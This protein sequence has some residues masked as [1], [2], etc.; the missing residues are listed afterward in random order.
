MR[1]DGRA[2]TCSYVP[3]IIHWEVL[4]VLI[5]SLFSAHGNK[6][7]HLKKL[8][9]SLPSGHFQTKVALRLYKNN[10]M[11]E[12]NDAAHA[13]KRKYLRKYSLETRE[14]VQASRLSK[15]NTKKKTPVTAATKRDRDRN[16]HAVSIVL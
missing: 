6:M 15:S 8:P 2:N 1:D 11:G 16:I 13:I 14:M 4:A 5:A 9:S 10:E 12:N 7:Y 3:S